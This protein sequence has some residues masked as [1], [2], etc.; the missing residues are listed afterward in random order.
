[1]TVGSESVVATSTGAGGVMVAGA[2]NMLVVAIVAGVR[3]GVIMAGG[4]VAVAASA[5]AAQRHSSSGM[6]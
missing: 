5:T 1:M 4:N 3:D 2:G 6:S